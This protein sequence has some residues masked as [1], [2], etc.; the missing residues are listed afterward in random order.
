MGGVLAL[1]TQKN[2]AGGRKK[3]TGVIVNGVCTVISPVKRK[4]CVLNVEVPTGKS[5]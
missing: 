4:G 3:K 2:K 5:K 1:S